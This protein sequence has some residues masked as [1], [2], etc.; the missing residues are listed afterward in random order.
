MI[1]LFRNSETPN[2]VE[3]QIGDQLRFP[4]KSD[5]MIEREIYGFKL[6]KLV[7]EN[8][9][10]T[11]IIEVN[12]GRIK[13]FGCSVRGNFKLR[14][15]KHDT[16]GEKQ[17]AL[18][19]DGKQLGKTF[20]KRAN[21]LQ[22]YIDLI[23]KHFNKLNSW[24]VTNNGN[25]IEFQQ[26]DD[27]D[28][29]GKS[30]SIG[31]G[32]YNKLNRNNPCIT[33][34]FLATEEVIGNKCYQ[35]D[36]TDIVEGN[37][38]TVN[39]VTTRA[40]KGDTEATLR[41]KILG[42]NKY[43]CVLNTETYT[44]SAN[45]G[46]RTILNTNKPEI[47]L[48]YSSSDATYDYYTVNTYNVRSGNI[49]DI[50]GIQKIAGESDTQ[51]TINTFFNS[52]SG[53]FRIAKGT[54]I[55]ATALAGRR[56]VANTNDPTITASLT[57]TTTTADKDKFLVSI[58]NDVQKG[59]EYVLDGIVYVAKEG[60]TD[61]DVAFG[62]AGANTASFFYYLPETVEPVAYANKGYNRGEENIADVQ[63]LCSTIKC[64]DKKSIIF[65]FE[66]LEL[67]CYQGIILDNY[68]TEIA[69]TSAIKVLSEVDTEFVE[70]KNN[71]DAYGLEF[72]KL[73]WFKLRLP[74]S[75]KDTSPLIYEEIQKS[76]TGQQ[77]RGKT[78]I[79]T[80]RNFVT[81]NIDTESHDFL[82]KALKCDFLKIG[83]VEYSFLGE[84]NIEEHRQGI[85]DQ[86]MATG[87]L[88]VRN[89]LQTNLKNCGVGC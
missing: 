20:R 14:I 40:V 69:Y 65:E 33:T 68:G 79:E 89:N 13:P 42:S 87:Q 54:A 72:D 24:E 28:N 76:T 8:C 44:I 37:E 25:I 34:E 60:D 73:E 26:I 7:S 32:N 59:N 74:L 83:G 16:T 78:T 51:T 18:Y 9:N 5:W 57:T 21:T 67:G 38:F 75:L 64:C 31:V 43:L 52:H 70:F 41:A 36:I 12:N 10:E 50:N 82:L 48:F 84:Y 47:K 11:E 17:F 53:F 23:V 88:T 81:K 2:V 46:L 1:K 86:R 63:L 58:C 80:V 45:P 15:I 29:C 62:L 6:N 77:T 85:K 55:N 66:G 19:L 3:C 61:I 71:T 35:L 22:E 56:I 49:F 39:G 27:C 4:V 30:L